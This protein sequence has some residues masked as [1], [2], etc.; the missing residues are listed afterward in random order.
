MEVTQE[1][2]RRLLQMPGH[3]PCR[4]QLH[5]LDPEVDHILCSVP[6]LCYPMPDIALPL[7]R[8]RFGYPPVSATQLA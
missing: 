8:Y 5:V 3:S 2:Y 7:L 1:G 6:V 4:A